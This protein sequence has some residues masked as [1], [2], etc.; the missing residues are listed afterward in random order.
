MKKNHVL[1]WASIIVLAISVFIGISKCTKTT[2]T[3]TPPIRTV[4]STATATQTQPAIPTRDPEIL[5]S[6]T[7]TPIPTV[8]QTP[9]LSFP[10]KVPDCGDAIYASQNKDECPEFQPAMCSDDW[11]LE[12]WQPECQE[13]LDHW[14]VDLQ[15]STQE[16]I[17]ILQIGP[18][19]FEW[20]LDT[21]LQQFEN[22][23]NMYVFERPFLA[24]SLNS[25]GERVRC[26]EVEPPE[27]GGVPIVVVKDFSSVRYYDNF[28]DYDLNNYYLYSWY[29]DNSNPTG[30]Q[31]LSAA[32]QVEGTT[33]PEPP[34]DPNEC[35]EAPPVN[36]DGRPGEFKVWLCG[37]T[38]WGEWITPEGQLIIGPLPLPLVYEGASFLLC[39]PSSRY[40]TP[41]ISEACNP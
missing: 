17:F 21:Q 2:N 12:T 24:C 37:E 30:C 41:Y 4:E 11:Y 33:P 10:T 15:D 25:D 31:D 14:L 3:P 29:L 22:F 32:F 27:G 34:F 28:T 40:P 6:A 8:T 35:I 18:T 23:C 5:P 1:F 36:S 26:Y 19:D 16:Q 20:M 7:R 39:P 9:R 38:Y 13:Y